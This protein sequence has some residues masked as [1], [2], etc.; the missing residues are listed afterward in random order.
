MIINAVKK[1]NQK[2]QPRC[3]ALTVPTTGIIYRQQKGEDWEEGEGEGFTDISTGAAVSPAPTGCPVCCTG[4][5]IQPSIH[6]PANP[7]Q[8]LGLAGIRREVQTN[9]IL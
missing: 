5:S 7:Y 6:L 8:G 3:A 4:N 9:R 2:K 1:T